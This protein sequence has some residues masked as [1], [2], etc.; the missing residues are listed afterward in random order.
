MADLHK[1]SIHDTNY[2]WLFPPTE[3][4]NDYQRR[5]S[6]EYMVRYIHK[7]VGRRNLSLWIGRERQPST[8]RHT[9][10]APTG[11]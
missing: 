6:F 8:D 4:K 7:Q 5:A 3:V 9:H 2:R 11:N 1:I 10:Q